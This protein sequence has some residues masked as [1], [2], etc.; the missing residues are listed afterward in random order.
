MSKTVVDL[1]GVHMFPEGHLD[2]IH[3]WQGTDR[4]PHVVGHQERE[5]G[6]TPIGPQSETDRYAAILVNRQPLDEAKV[7]DRFIE[8]RIGDA[9]ERLANRRLALG[10]VETYA[11]TL[12]RALAAIFCLCV[13]T[14]MS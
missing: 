3:P 8:F 6:G 2:L 11:A 14:S 7:R 10:F 1:V 4:T 9:V 12:A 5:V 13:S